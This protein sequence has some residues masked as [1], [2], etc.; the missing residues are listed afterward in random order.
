MSNIT[1]RE[2]L[3]IAQRDAWKAVAEDQYGKLRAMLYGPETDYPTDGALDAYAA[4]K[5]PVLKETSTPIPFAGYDP[6]F[7]PGSDPNNP[8]PEEHQDEVPYAYE[9]LTPLSNGMWCGNFG[10][11]PPKSGAGYKNVKPLYEHPKQDR[12]IQRGNAR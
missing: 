3:L 10:Y 8:Q 11:A 9:W 4:G 1:E 5:H 2:A 7:V 12:L 6:N